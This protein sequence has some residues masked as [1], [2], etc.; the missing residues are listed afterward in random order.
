MLTLV[1]ISIILSFILHWVV[2]IVYW[3]K[4][5]IVFKF[6]KTLSN[7]LNKKKNKNN[8]QD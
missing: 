6:W 4:W 1:G 5:A 8:V 3:I 2:Y 7:L